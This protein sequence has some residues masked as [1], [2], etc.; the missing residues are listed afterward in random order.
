MLNKLN[1]IYTFK[2]TKKNFLLYS[3]MQVKA[4]YKI[5]FV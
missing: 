3:N 2:G 1:T 5:I 4:N